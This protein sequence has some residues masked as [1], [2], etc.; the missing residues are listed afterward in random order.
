MT[1]GEGA[2]FSLLLILLCECGPST[3]AERHINLYL[4]LGA[5]CIIANC[6][7][8][9]FV[10]RRC[11]NRLLKPV[12][13]NLGIIFV[14]CLLY[15]VKLVEMGATL[16]PLRELGYGDGLTAVFYIGTYIGVSLLVRFLLLIGVK[17]YN[18]NV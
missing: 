16:F 7:L 8:F 17:I 2:V 13:L 18:S 9:Y 14:L 1:A 12:C 11:G 3:F 15:F 10:L 4:L 5:V 6:I